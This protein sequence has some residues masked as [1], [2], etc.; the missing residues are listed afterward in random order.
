MKHKHV[1]ATAFRHSAFWPLPRPLKNSREAEV[2]HRNQVLFSGKLQGWCN[3]GP[4]APH[5]I[6]SNI[7]RKQLSLSYHY[8]VYL[9]VKQCTQHYKCKMLYFFRSSFFSI[10][11]KLNP[12]GVIEIL[13][14]WV[15]VSHRQSH[16]GDGIVAYQAFMSKT[17]DVLNKYNPRLCNHCTLMET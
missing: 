11:F 6:M 10:P 16:R 8:I 4:S 7:K 2:L 3:F 14:S 13:H 5:L 17:K 15:S 9:W 1:A 12:R